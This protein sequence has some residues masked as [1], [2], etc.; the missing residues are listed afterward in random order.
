MTYLQVNRLAIFRRGKVVYDQIFP[1]KINILRGENGSGKST[2]ANFIYYALGGDFID[3]LPEARSCETVFVEVE[4]NSKTLTLKRD[5]ADKLMQPMFIFLG[6]LNNALQHAAEGW[7]FYT[8]RKGDRKESFTQFMFRALDFPEVVT[9]NNETL[10]LNQV[11]RVLYIDQISPL[12]TLLKTVDFDSPLIRQALGYILLGIYDNALFNQQLDLKNKRKELNDLEREFRAVN[13]VYKSSQ[14]SIDINRV[15]QAIK[16][17][18]DALWKIDQTLKSRDLTSTANKEEFT[19]IRDLQAKTQATSKEVQNALN[20]ISKIEAEIIDSEDFIAELEKQALALEESLHTRETLGE[21]ELTFCPSCLSKLEPIEGESTCKLCKQEINKEEHK[22]RV[23]RI[24]REIQNQI[25]ESQ[26]LL[27]RKVN[28]EDKL[29]NDITVL[30]K[31]LSL[32]S[33][34]L[35]SFIERVSSKGNRKH[36]EL[37]IRKGELR[38]EI[39]NLLQQKK[40]INSFLELQKRVTTLKIKVDTLTTEVNFKEEIQKKRMSIALEKIQYY[41]LKLLRGDGN[42]EEAFVNA[43]RITTDFY[44]NTYA[45][46]ERKVFSASSLVILKNSIRFGIFFASLELDFMRYPKFILCDNVEDKG[47]REERSHNFQRNVVELANGF[48]QT[49]FQ[50]IFTTSMIDQSLDIPQ[51][52]IGDYYTPENKSLSFE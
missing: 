6:P 25:K 47:M 8:Y 17:S 52:T 14:Q 34:D 19:Q 12:N 16:E 48:P 10:T 42:Y 22:A 28:E 41:S 50:I 2:I 35:N 51:Y 3:W 49:Q 5:I 23:L 38:S 27:S 44:S 33:R 32:E 30:K 29:E 18:E 40:I 20:T 26:Y 43:T 37:L 13:E 4:I 9:D 1:H 46:D 7:E 11:L 31:R 15:E 21:L 39:N 45:V 24:L 36:D